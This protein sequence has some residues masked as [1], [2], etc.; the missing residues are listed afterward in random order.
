[1]DAPGQPPRNDANPMDGLDETEAETPT[2][3]ARFVLF[4]RYEVRRELGSGGMGRVVLARDT[5]LGIDVAVKILPASV[6]GDPAAIDELRKE[7]RRGM[8]LSH[9]GIARTHNFEQDEEGAGIMMGYIDGETLTHRIASRIH[10]CFDCKDIVEWV[11]QLCAALDY[12]HRDARIVHRDLKPRNLLVTQPLPTF[13]R[14]R[15][16]VADFGLSSAIHDSV[17]RNSREGITSGTP[18]YMS[19][20]QA[21][22]EKPTHLD[23][24]YSL[25]ATIYELLTGRPPFYQGNI[26]MQINDL[27]PPAMAQRRAEF[28]IRGMNEIPHAW[29]KT[30]A[31]CLVKNPANRPQSAGEVLARIMVSEVPTVRT[32]VSPELG[33]RKPEHPAGFAH[34]FSRLHRHLGR[35][36]WII[37]AVL[38]FA[39]MLSLYMKKRLRDAEPAAPP[40]TGSAPAETVRPAALPLV[41][42]F[43][44][45][46][47]AATASAPFVNE[48]GMKF[49]PVPI[50]GAGSGASKVFFGTTETTVE[51][52]G[53]F[54]T[55]TNRP[56]P[57]PDFAIGPDHPAV[58]VTW[59]DAKAFCAWLTDTERAAGRLPEAGRYR[60]PTDHEWS[61]AV[62]IGDREDAAQSPKE[63]RG[64]V[65]DVYPWGT[66]WPPPARAGNYADATA[67]Q[68]GAAPLAIEGYDDGFAQTCPVEAFPANGLGIHGLG[69]NASEWCDDW[70][71]PQKKEART[72]R[73]GC[74]RDSDES[75]LRTSF[76]GSFDPALRFAGYGFR[77][78][79]EVAAATR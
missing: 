58:S 75:Y 14:G 48:L 27:I 20:Q 11:E 63:K 42:V 4:G 71:D 50:A 51:Q 78:V 32:A 16:K 36:P 34:R 52:Y 12:A 8:A 47:E 74:W 55:A 10:G 39:L 35:W 18:P 15:I 62:G 28:G 76:R 19:P 38:A 54:V 30:I 43:R 9:P 23:D 44:E 46:L 22:G 5:K 31:A 60:L 29:E 33:E 79:L 25:G 49:V 41:T 77:C 56:W 6:A 61:C 3:S 2:K 72:V 57:K 68:A 69:G 37:A 24:V 40:E 21:R 17:A 73:G 53:K 64:A 65:P 7:V 26:A 70:Y 45:R 1:M 66:A 67:V 59:D 13:S